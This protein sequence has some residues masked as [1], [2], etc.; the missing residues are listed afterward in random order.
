MDSNHDILNQNQLYYPYTIGQSS[1]SHRMGCKNR[2]GQQ[3]FQ[4]FYIHTSQSFPH[5]SRKRFCSSHCWLYE[6][7]VSWVRRRGGNGEWAIV[8]RGSTVKRP[9]LTRRTNHPYSPFTIHHS[10]LTIYDQQTHPP[11]GICIQYD[12]YVIQF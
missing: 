6:K 2:A 8:N 5:S 7:S 4:I 10:Q 1:H 9:P 3:L 11:C 12:P